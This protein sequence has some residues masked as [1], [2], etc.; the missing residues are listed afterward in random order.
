MG[1]AEKASAEPQLSA[2]AAE[3]TGEAGADSTTKQ[4]AHPLP[5]ASTALQGSMNGTERAAQHRA[6]RRAA[7]N[8]TAGSRLA[9]QQLELEHN[10]ASDSRPS[11]G[12]TVTPQQHLPPCTLQ[13][14]A[15]S[16]PIEALWDQPANVQAAHS[17]LTAFLQKSGLSQYLSMEPTE[18]CAA[19]RLSG[20][21]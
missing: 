7:S 16:T 8:P 9:A 21:I 3:Q 2:A 1:N 10:S 20:T 12:V 6:D 13:G 18:V 15:A 5:S 11:N 17:A 4:S 14:E 19:P